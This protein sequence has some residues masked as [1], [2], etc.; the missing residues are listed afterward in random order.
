MYAKLKL[1]EYLLSPT[2]I[3]LLNT[4][5]KPRGSVTNTKP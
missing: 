5:C 3:V 1:I 4:N 2:V